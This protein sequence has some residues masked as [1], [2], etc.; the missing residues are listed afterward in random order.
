MNTIVIDA[1]VVA[2]ILKADR[3]RE[4]YQADRRPEEYWISYQGGG[5]VQRGVVMQMVQT[6]LLRRKYPDCECYELAANDKLRHG[7]KEKHE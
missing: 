4:I 6:G 2:E 3:R 5:P 1:N 7:E